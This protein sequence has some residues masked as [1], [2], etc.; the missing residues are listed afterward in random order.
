MRRWSFAYR[1]ALTILATVVLAGCPVAS[2]PDS[3]PEANFTATPRTG[4]TGLAVAF[5]DL[6]TTV[7]GGSIVSWRW[8]F[9]DGS[10][11]DEPNPIHTYLTPGDFTVSLTVTSSGGSH[12]RT[13]PG[14][15]RISS[16][17]GSDQLD[18]RGG[19]VSA[20][21]VSIAVPEGALDGR[22]DFGI[23]LV[24]EEISF[25]VFESINRVGDTF[26][27]T[28][29]SDA[30]LSTTSDADPVQPTT[31]SIP[32]AED[33]VPTGNRTAA[34]VH[35]I[36]QLASGEVIPILGR[37]RAGRIEAQVLD[38]PESALYT[39]VYRPDAYLATAAPEA[40]APTTGD[41]ADAW[42]VGLSPALLAQLTAL[43]LGSVEQASSFFEREFTDEE[44][45][46][47]ETAL[48]D[49][50]ATLHQQLETAGAR[51]PRLLPV[52]GNYVAL[53][54]NF[55][56]QYSTAPGSI[57]N[58]IYAASPFGQIVVDPA[59]LLALSAWNADRVAADPSRV[60]IAQVIGVKRAFAEVLASAVVAGYDYPDVTITSPAD[61]G[62]VHFAAGIE[63]GF[64]L[65][66]GQMAEGQT[67]NRSQLSGDVALLSTPVLAPVDASVSGYAAASQ[68]F[69]RYIAQRYAPESPLDYIVGDGGSV[70]G[71][72]EEVRLALDGLLSPSYTEVAALVATALDDAFTARLEQPLGAVYYDYAIDL[73]FVHSDASLLRPSDA[74]LLP[75]VL[76]TSRF[77]EG[78]ILSGELS[79]PSDGLD[80]PGTGQ[81]GLTAIAPLSTRVAVV[82]ADPASDTLE[83]EF[84]ADEWNA[85]SNG[86]GIEVIVYR[87]GLPGTPLPAGESTLSFSGFAAD[88]GS[89][90][91][92]FYVIIVNSSTSTESSVEITAIGSV[93]E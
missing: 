67:V 29:D 2:G 22:V 1:S 87:E 39:V 9:G 65:Y 23:T 43:R 38:L 92:F 86:Q 55:L 74:D 58:V 15:I 46:D 42:S 49:G 30:A 60:D 50:I 70:K 26:Q 81:T 85:D 10:E 54:Y 14:Y 59:Q 41:W 31:L 48:T 4:N 84:N 19:T 17:A 53:C 34:S 89:D 16:P 5:T 76:D 7:T 63:S 3:R 27:I 44:L 71:T 75:L 72:L 12:T 36:A 8:N 45:A 51:S 20:N 35:I 82:A 37:I 21:G 77:A 47:T 32:Y 11:S 78:S 90:K 40:K 56:V 18:E 66:L 68:D 13:R 91:A 6:S 33:V 62:E 64:A 69:Y 28:H 52:S 57:D 83:F 79:G 25:N 24:D 73:A 88:A 61:G 93:T 80:F